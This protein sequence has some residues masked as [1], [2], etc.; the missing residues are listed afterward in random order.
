ML[1]DKP[2]PSGEGAG[3]SHRVLVV[4]DEPNI[5]ESLSFLMKR[6]GFDVQVA[7]DGT[8]A[9]QM[10]ERDRPDLVVLDVMLP[11]R[12]GYDVCRTIRANRRLDGVRIM[13][14]SA[15]GRELD[16]RKG[17]ALGADDYVTKPFSTRELVDRARAL[18]GSSQG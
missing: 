15:K 18:L 9:L 3:V 7:S 6:E 12:D 10:V 8:S 2:Q 17:L 16:R 14:L 11:R 1:V 13:M 4:E 5:A